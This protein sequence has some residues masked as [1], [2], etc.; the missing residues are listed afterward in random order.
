M[1]GKRTSSKEDVGKRNSIGVPILKRRGNIREIE[2][3]SI[4]ER[5]VNRL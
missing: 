1:K 3:K 4:S 2:K 5:K